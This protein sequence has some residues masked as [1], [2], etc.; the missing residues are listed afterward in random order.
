MFSLMI[1]SRELAVTGN[2]F[3]GKS[4]IPERDD[5]TSFDKNTVFG[6][7][8]SWQFFNHD[9]SDKQRNNEH[10]AGNRTGD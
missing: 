1:N 9:N 3:L 6:Q 7:L 8:N 5:I 2:V 4:T 10:N